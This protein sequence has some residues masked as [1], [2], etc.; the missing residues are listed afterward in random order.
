VEVVVHE[1][2]LPD[3]QAVSARVAHDALASQRLAQAGYIGVHAARRARR[4]LLA[5]ESIGQ[6]IR[7]DRLAG[8]KQQDRE[9]GPLLAA[10]DVDRV[11]VLAHVER[12]EDAE[13]LHRRSSFAGCERPSSEVQARFMAPPRPAKHIRRRRCMHVAA[14]TVYWLRSADRKSVV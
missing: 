4:R 2:A 13:L 11:T 10:T 3:G 9:Q 12:P 5:P 1:L 7:G 14:P 8:V 6:T